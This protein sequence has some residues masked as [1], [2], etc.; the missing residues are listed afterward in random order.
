MSDQPNRQPTAEELLAGKDRAIGEI[1]CRMR[2]L[3]DAYIQLSREHEALKKRLEA[4]D[5]KKA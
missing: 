5:T 2:A 4:Q 3:E 1:Y